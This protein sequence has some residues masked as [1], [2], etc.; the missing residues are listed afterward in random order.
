MLKRAL[1][2]KEAASYIGRSMSFLTHGR[3]NGELQNRTPT[4]PFVKQGRN[5]VYLIED[6]DTWLE[7]FPKV[8]HL[9]ELNRGAS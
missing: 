5:I 3:I 1:S 7:S 9:A 2:T 6:L 4:P 8:K